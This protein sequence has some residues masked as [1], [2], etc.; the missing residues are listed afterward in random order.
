MALF[1]TNQSMLEDHKNRFICIL[2]Y[3]ARGIKSTKF[4]SDKVFEKLH[5]NG[6]TDKHGARAELIQFL[7]DELQPRIQYDGS[8]NTVNLTDQGLRWAEGVKDK[9]PYLEYRPLLNG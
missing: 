2:Y 9:P 1:Y 4:D 6:F 3:L 5:A 7:Q 8:T